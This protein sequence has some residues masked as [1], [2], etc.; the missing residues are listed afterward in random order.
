LIGI[1]GVARKSPFIMQM[2]ADVMNMPIKIH[3]SEQTCAAGAAMFAATA[4]G[5]YSSVEHAMKN[6]GIGFDITYYPSAEKNKL[7]EKRYERYL[8]FASFNEKINQ[9]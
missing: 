9:Q 1:G 8:N 2:M 6:M 4:A 3:R 7:Y 5:I